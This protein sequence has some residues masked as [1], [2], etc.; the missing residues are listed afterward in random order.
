MVHKIKI[1]QKQRNLLEMFISS[2]KNNLNGNAKNFVPF[3]TSD[4][5][6]YLC[7]KSI[8]NDLYN[9]IKSNIYNYFNLTFYKNKIPQLNMAIQKFDIYETLTLSTYRNYLDEPDYIK[10]LN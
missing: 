4:R 10:K 8:Y 6:L 7:S 5:K 1:L 2:L 3:L 9:N